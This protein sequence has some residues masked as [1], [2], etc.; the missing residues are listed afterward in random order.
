MALWDFLRRRKDE[1][2]AK[3]PP[4][5]PTADPVGTV[6]ELEPL[7]QSDRKNP[8]AVVSAVLR[9]AQE[10]GRAARYRDFE[11]M[12]TGDIAAMIDAVVDS[13]LTFEDVSTGRGFKIESDN[14]TVEQILQTAVRVGDLQQLADEVC[15]EMVKYGDAFVEPV[16]VGSE[17]VGAQTYAPSE[18]TRT[19]DDK[20]RLVRGKDDDGFYVA[21][22]QKRNGQ[23]VAGWQPWEMIH[24]KFAPSRRLIYS[25]KS[26]LDDIRTDWKKLQLVEQGMVVARITRAYPRRVHYL[27]VTNK[28][29]VEQEQLLTRYIARMTKKVLGRKPETEDGFPVADVSED[30][31]LTTGYMTGP[32]GKPVPRLN[33]VETEDPAIAGLAA[34]SDVEYLRG[35]LWSAVPSDVVGIIRNTLGD[36]NSQ[37]VAYTRLVRRVQ[38]QLE[39]GLRA[40]FDQI[41]LTKGYLPGS[42]EYRVVLP[43]VDIKASWKH[44]DARFRASMTL[45]NYAEMGAISRRFMLRQ[46]YNLSDLEID[47]IWK[48][49][50]SEATNPIFAPVLP[51]RDGP[52]TIVGAINKAGNDNTPVPSRPTTIPADAGRAVTKNGID[53]GTDLGQMLRGNNSA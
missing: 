44:S 41:L 38:R 43:T 53:R 26:L 23:V 31:Y 48:E 32:D 52:P 18:I 49:I 17:F 16:F 22:Q 24:F 4:A 14:P 40:L 10:R 45:R 46:A 42:V 33:R 2:T 19:Q 6:G 34:M 11:L 13:A 8:A 27:D 37:D 47:R 12:D 35:K 20:G 50:E 30:L 9:T 15:R 5:T 29:K 25:A 1:Q 7:A 39:V 3:A 51:A 36:M 21:F 28:E